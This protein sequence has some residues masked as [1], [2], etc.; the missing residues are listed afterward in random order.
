MRS[1]CRNVRRFTNILSASLFFPILAQKWLVSLILIKHKSQSASS[2][3]DWP[4]WLVSV[5]S[6]MLWIGVG[7]EE[8]PNRL[9]RCCQ[10]ALMSSEN[11][12]GQRKRM[13]AKAEIVSGFS[14]TGLRRKLTTVGFVGGTEQ[15]LLTERFFS[16]MTSE[17]YACL[18]RSWRPFSRKRLQRATVITYTFVMSLDVRRHEGWPSVSS[19]DWRHFLS[20]RE[21]SNVEVPAGWIATV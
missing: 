7:N 3:C 6:A 10:G 20:T 18:H 1:I 21:D 11:T 17:R 4:K 16:E 13:S 2:S 19:G 5:F 9:V 12:P 15:H 8:N 14:K